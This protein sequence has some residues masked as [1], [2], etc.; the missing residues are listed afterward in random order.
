MRHNTIHQDTKAASTAATAS[1]SSKAASPESA[2]AADASQT[3]FTEGWL[4]RLHK[5]GENP[6]IDP[7]LMEE[8]LKF[9]GGK[10]FTRFP[11]EP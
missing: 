9:T 4:S 3:M 1:S 2:E 11:P 6:Q 7:K 8:H 10:V 5:P